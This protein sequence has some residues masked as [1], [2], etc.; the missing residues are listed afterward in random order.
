M[1]ARA[2]SFPRSSARRTARPV[3]LAIIIRHDLSA[4]FFLVPLHVM[5]QFVCNGET[6]TL[7]PVLGCVRPREQHAIWPGPVRGTCTLRSLRRRKRG[8]PVAAYLSYLSTCVCKP[9]PFNLLNL[10]RPLIPRI[11]RVRI[12]VDFLPREGKGRE[13]REKENWEQPAT[14]AGRSSER[15]ISGTRRWPGGLTL[16]RIPHLPLLFLS[17]PNPASSGG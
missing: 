4:H 11:H 2:T 14:E 9:H 7:P 8:E 3:P 5:V 15:G 16:P 10:P 12:H 17:L 6:R 1:C 13:E